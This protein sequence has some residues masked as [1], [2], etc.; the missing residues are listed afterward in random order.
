MADR[1]STLPVETIVHIASYLDAADISSWR[2]ASKQ[3]SD[4]LTATAFRHL[5]VRFTTDSNQRLM[6]IAE[7]DGLR[8]FVR[9]IQLDLKSRPGTNICFCGEDPLAL[10]RFMRSETGRTWMRQDDQSGSV[11]NRALIKSIHRQTRA[12]F[13]R[14]INTQELVLD[15]RALQ[16]R[17][18]GRDTGPCKPILDL[19]RDLSRHFPSLKSFRLYS[20][21]FSNLFPMDPD[22]A[23]VSRA[24]PPLPTTIGQVFWR[25]L[26]HL[27][28]GLGD[29]WSALRSQPV[30]EGFLDLANAINA[31]DDLSSLEINSEI[32]LPDIFLA[33]RQA[34]APSNDAVSPDMQAKIPN[35]DRL[36]LSGT[37]GTTDQYN[38]ILNGAAKTLQSV[39]LVNCRVHWAFVKE[40]NDLNQIFT[41]WPQINDFTQ[42]WVRDPRNPESRMAPVPSD[43][44]QISTYFEDLGR[45]GLSLNPPPELRHMKF[46]DASGYIWF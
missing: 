7:N 41:F 14:L 29:S 10:N 12:I 15:L 40:R 26:R 25:H 39:E 9:V 23:P 30:D 11:A 38:F 19:I 45:P 21:S 18:G 36:R 13:S 2:L 31:I 3:F 42:S 17:H 28:I 46:R 6:A 27:C 43:M 5:V 4:V 44:E 16:C 8:R 24:C 34:A 1:I 35:L 32:Q 37:L 22:Y 20:S 33:L